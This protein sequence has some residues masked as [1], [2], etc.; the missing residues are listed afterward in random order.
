[1]KKFQLDINKIDPFPFPFVV[2]NWK[3]LISFDDEP[4]RKL[5]IS[6]YGEI[7]H[8]AKLTSRLNVHVSQF[9]LLLLFVDSIENVTYVVDMFPKKKLI[10]FSWYFVFTCR[11]L[12]LDVLLPAF[13]FSTLLSPCCHL[14]IF[15]PSIPSAF[16]VCLLHISVCILSCLKTPFLYSCCLFYSFMYIH[17][18]FFF[19]K[20][21]SYIEFFT[22]TS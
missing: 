15:P 17:R 6:L 11:F 8:K 7:P 3:N 1:M 10:Y 12:I 18:I 21:F 13:V 4:Q 19:H 16:T 14:W 9:F 22:K 20:F 2:L 5:H